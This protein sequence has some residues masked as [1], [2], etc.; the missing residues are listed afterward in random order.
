[1]N[2]ESLDVLLAGLASVAEAAGVADPDGDSDRSARRLRDHLETRTAAGLLVFD[3][4]ADPDM[5]R[6]FLPAAGGTQLVVTSTDRAFADW[7]VLVD[8]SVFT[9]PESVGY[10]TERTSLADLPG[11]HGVSGQLGDLPLALAQAA[12]VIRHRHWTYAR[13]LSELGRVPVEQLLRRAPGADYPQSA[14]A[15]LRTPTHLAWPAC[16]CGWWRCCRPMGCAGI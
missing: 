8:V 9:R 7:G 2:A 3:N 14:A 13:Y 15:A 12:A 6:P 16:C 5:L 11:A 10:L 1:V 4:A